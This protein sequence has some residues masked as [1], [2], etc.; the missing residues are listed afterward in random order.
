MKTRLHP[1]IILENLFSSLIF[2]IFIGYYIISQMLG[3]F[4]ES[5]IENTA[6]TL[7]SLGLGI[8]GL[9]ILTIIIIL[10]IFT[11]FFWIRWKNTYLSFND[12]SVVIE[13]GRLFKK[14]TT[15]HLKDIAT[16]NIK[17]NILE[18]ILGTSNIKIDLN[19]T[20]ETY[21]GKLIFKENKAIE[22]KNEILSKTG[23]EVST[24]TEEIESLVKYDNLDVLKHLFFSINIISIIILI[25]TYL[26]IVMLV[27]EES[28]ATGII[29]GILPLL[30]IVFPLVWSFIKTF[31]GYYNFKCSRENDNIKL[32]YGA[33]T[34]YKYSLPIK[35]INAVIIHQTL[36]ARIFGYYLI[37]VVNAGIGEDEEEKTII[38]LYVKEKEK[39]TII[40]EI[41]PE[42]K[43]EIKP[44]RDNISILKHYITAKILWIILS[45]ILIPFTSYISL[46]LIPLALLVSLLQYNTN[47]IGHNKD[48]II[49][50]NGII[51]K[52][53]TITKYNNIELIKSK[54]KLFSSFFKTK[55]LQI[56]VVGP[57]T[58]NTFTSG[59]F[60]KQTIEEIINIY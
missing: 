52:K 23:K 45:I 9:I 33:L 57:M 49:I 15:I 25:I 55:T 13:K 39:N 29:F 34:T 40:N 31:L 26:I 4:S 46:I 56:N 41:L 38:S 2:I 17:R 14:V 1:S 16:I 5:E 59:L 42:Y 27:M 53:T 30:I 43:N 44:K 47:K 18:K 22:I 60:Q 3:D 20:G 35:K 36:Q 58:N 32:S 50:S 48:M 7:I 54:Q 10:I 21:N 51:N 28:K 8:Y 12:D 37:E 19:T 6:Q 24:E 11:I